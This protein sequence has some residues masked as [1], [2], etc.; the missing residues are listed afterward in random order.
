MTYCS[1]LGRYYNNSLLAV[2]SNSI[3]IATLSRLDQMNYVNLYKQTKIQNIDKTEGERLGFRT[4]A[5]TKPAIIGLLK[6]A[7]DEE[8]IMIPSAYILQEL[9]DFIQTDTGRTEAAEGCHDDSVIALAIAV[10]VLR[11]HGHMLMNDRVSWKDKIG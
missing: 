6:N 9:K 3:G 10:E 7:I 8:D 11:T 5:L 1:I 4:T 2:E